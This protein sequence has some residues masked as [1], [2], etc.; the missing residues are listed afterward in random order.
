VVPLLSARIIRLSA[1][2]AAV[3]VAI[4]LSAC[5]GSSGGGSSGGGSGSTSSSSGSGSGSS[6]ATTTSAGSVSGKQVFLSAGCSSCHTLAATHST[7]TIGPN[8]DTLKPS[9]SAVLKQVTYG[10]GGMPAFNSKLS[11]T[12]IEA[13]AKFVSSSTQ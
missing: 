8:L 10:G 5:G 13:V 3:I 2:I 1:P 12:Q 4:G 6:A 7:G 9:Y 11:Q